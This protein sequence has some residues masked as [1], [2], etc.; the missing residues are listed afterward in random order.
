VVICEGGRDLTQTIAANYAYAVRA[1]LILIPSTSDPTRESI[2]ERFYSS[3]QS[4]HASQSSILEAL[5]DEIRQLVGA[6]A[7]PEK[8]SI[9]F[10]TGGIPY[11]FAF[12]ELPST[13]LFTYPDLGISIINGFSAEQPG[14]AGVNVA[15]LIN[16]ETVEA[17]EVSLA[18]KCLAPRGVFFREYR[19]PTATVQHIS[20]MIE[21]FP[22][23]LLMIA[24]HCGDATGYRWTYEFVDSEGLQ[25]TLVVDVA[26]GVARTNDEELLDI[27]QFTNFVSLDG[28]DWH[29]PEKSE[30]LYVGTAIQDWVERTRGGGE[31]EPTIKVDIDRVTWS[32]ALKMYDHNYI[33]AS[34]A[35]ASGRTP[36]II[37]NACGS[38]HRLAGDFMFGNAR[39]YVG[40]LF[41][42]STAEVEEV[43]RYLFERE[44]QKPL[45]VAIWTS[46]RRVYQGTLRRPYVVTGVFTQ[47]LRSSPRDVPAEVYARLRTAHKEW[48]GFLS[49]KSPAD[50]M[51]QATKDI[52][53]FHERELRHFRALLR[54]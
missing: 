46:Q 9:T 40:T 3:D 44:F 18:I 21:F 23:D 28:V 22:Y 38:W 41:P 16:P 54:K 15:A 26:I 5:R 31:L 51:Y 32:S 37:N 1:G 27:V 47:W 29:D 25:R 43:T 17:P 36:I 20:A 42:I 49:G 12:P 45:A 7:L 35:V 24:T 2:L 13:H 11:G 14:A 52:V 48:M 10:I 8:G 50:T 19:G 33:A 6:V 34:R 4:R 53:D 30:K 39:A